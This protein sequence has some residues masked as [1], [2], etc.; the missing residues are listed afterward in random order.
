MSAVT[1]IA[2]EQI[3]RV[4]P[5][6]RPDRR[7]VMRQNWRHLLFLHWEVPF[8][9]LRALI[10][11]QLSIDMFDG[12]AYVG[13]VPFTMTG[14][15]PIW[16]PSIPP[17][18]DFHEV[19]VR[20]YVHL[21]GADPGVW[22]FSLDAAN[23]IAVRV[24]RTTFKLP[25]YFANID[26]QC[27]SVSGPCDCNTLGPPSGTP[28]EVLE[29]RSSRRWPQPVPAECAIRYRPTG[30]AGPSAVG[31]LEHFLAERYL[32]YT[33]D[34]RGLFRGQVHHTP[35]P[36][37]AADVESLDESMIAAAGID[38]PAASPLAHYAFGVDVDIFG[39]DRVQ[40]V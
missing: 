6:V 10:P 15:R 36:L 16:S 35:Y 13:L 37:Q 32:L 5:T 21:N 22:F 38:R 8:D 33:V 14:V 31:T 34:G 12:R 2:P 26:L 40:G 4:A 3:D 27:S 23:A 9:V 7:V 20:T 28:P 17:L 1:D 39:L 24:A 29:Y 30:T 19:N 25:Y 18:S 11:A